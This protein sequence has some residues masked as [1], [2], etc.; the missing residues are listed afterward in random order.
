MPVAGFAI[1]ATPYTNL[2]IALD[3]SMVFSATQLSE[4]TEDKS[5]F[6]LV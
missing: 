2:K 5:H 4:S 6:R 3:L 1:A